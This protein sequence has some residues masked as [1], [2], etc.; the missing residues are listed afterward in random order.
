MFCFD[1]FHI[2]WSWNFG[3]FCHKNYKTGQIYT[4]KK[5]ISQ[6]FPGLFFNKKKKKKKEQ[7]FDSQKTLIGG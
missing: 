6:K 3:K 7:K 1:F 4:R 2:L 5:N